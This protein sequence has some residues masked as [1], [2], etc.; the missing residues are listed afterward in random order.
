ML[1]TGAK[2]VLALNPGSIV[3]ESAETFNGTHVGPPSRHNVSIS[4]IEPPGWMLTPDNSRLAS[5]MLGFS[6]DN[7]LTLNPR[8][9]RWVC[10][11]SAL[12]R[13]PGTNERPGFPGVS[14]GTMV[15]SLVVR[16]V[17][18]PVLLPLNVKLSNSLSS[19]VHPPSVM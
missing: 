18:P 2:L 1:V 4:L 8:T 12:N 19:T 14:S 17:A 11:A 3:V 9:R 5:S 13:K 7:K 15:M 16:A 6:T 10:P